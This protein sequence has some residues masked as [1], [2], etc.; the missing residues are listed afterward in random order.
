MPTLKNK[1]RKQFFEYLFDGQQGYACVC[2]APGKH[3]RRYF[4]QNFFLWPSQKDELL[5]F[6]ER[7]GSQK[8]LWFCVNLF[9]KA[10]R[11]KEHALP[12]D[13][14]WA[15]LDTCNPADIEP[16]PNVVI[17]SSPGRFQTIWKVDTTLP[18]E[19]AEEYSKR[20]AYAYNE[21]GADI[22]GWDITQL[23]RVPFSSNLKYDTKPQVKLANAIEKPYTIDEFEQLDQVSS[24][25]ASLGEISDAPDLET[26]PQPELIIYKYSANLKKTAFESL[27]TVEP[28]RNDDWSKLL[29]RLINVCLEA[30]MSVEETFAIAESAG[31]NKYKRDNRPASYL[32][33]DVLKAE[34]SQSKLTLVTAK[35][36]PL[37]IP[38]L[39]SKTDCSRTFI[40]T[41]GE[42]ATSATDALPSYH[43]VTAFILLSSFLAGGLY[44]KTNYVAKFIPNL[45]ALILGDSTLTR[46][47]T[48]MRMG[49]DMIME[50]DDEIILATDGSVEGLLSGLSIRPSRTSVFYKDEV[51]GF[52]DSINRKDYLAGMPETLT[53]LYDVPPI[54]TRRLR[55]EVISISNP[56]FIFF[57]GGIRDKVYSLL[58][59]EFILSGFLPRFLVVSGDADISRIRRTGPAGE[60][61]TEQR[62]DIKTSLMDMYESY[63]RVAEIK[64]GGQSVEV[65]A[66]IEAKL[67]KEAW[68][69]YGDIEMQMV[70]KASESPIR[71]L[72]LPTFERLSRSLLKMSML[73]A[74]SRQSPDESNQIVVTQQDILNAAWYIQDWGRHTI[75]LM[76]NTGKGMT[77]RELEKILEAIRRNPGVTRSW[78]M[79]R[80]HK[81]KREMDEILGTLVDRGEVYQ[82]KVGR[83]VELWVV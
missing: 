73:L 46:K 21:N 58:S 50:I 23:L 59:E 12:G 29:W 82:K 57:G 63:N 81:T 75:E 53:Q 40:D 80:Y 66:G 15:D 39:V 61:I 25:G 30:G 35:F 69:A 24:N 20:I 14:V 8:N 6:I 72:A 67:D 22:S 64:L 79:Q 54:Y 16:A 36:A 33:R 11:T 13:I 52:I 26:L 47:T 4:T 2:V 38:E 70:E 31:C 44:L 74:A 37:Q 71:T 78:I 43:D 77:Q 76:S 1:L 32:W 49:I 7:T 18:P 62:Q 42:W 19:Q 34:S 10:E 45:W 65:E 56:I 41:Y 27:Y 51:S 55:K 17:E 83:G 28:N 9:D 5:T 68:Q 3:A 48:A 60:V